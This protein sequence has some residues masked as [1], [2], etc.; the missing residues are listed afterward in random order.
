MGE[1]PTYCLLEGLPKWYW[2]EILKLKFIFSEFCSVDDFN[3]G[4]ILTT[5][6]SPLVYQEPVLCQSS[7]VQH[8]ACTIVWYSPR[9]EDERY[10]IPPQV[11]KD[12]TMND[13]FQM[14]GQIVEMRLSALVD[15][16][17]DR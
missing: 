10:Q 1:N 4:E 13:L 15:G 3:S 11:W 16:W 8:A 2:Y 6:V 9:S 5:G 12:E 7:D 17:M 14:I